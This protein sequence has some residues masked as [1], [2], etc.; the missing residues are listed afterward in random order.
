MQHLRS[1][2]IDQRQDIMLSLAYSYTQTSMLYYLRWWRI[3]WRQH[4][5]SGWAGWRRIHRWLH[6]A[7]SRQ[8]FSMC[9]GTTCSHSLVAVVAQKYIVELIVHRQ[10]ILCTV[11]NAQSCIASCLKR[12]AIPSSKIYE[13]FIAETN[14]P[15]ITAS[16]WITWC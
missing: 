12:I 6:G 4:D 9:R 8:W 14:G 11:V 5:V 2:R 7:H 16:P 3:D 1:W 15:V 10:Q 13:S